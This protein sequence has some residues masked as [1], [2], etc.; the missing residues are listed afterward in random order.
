MNQNPEVSTSTETPQDKTWLPLII[1]LLAQIQMAFNV[2]ALPVSVGPI[3]ET[4][5]TSATS[6]GTALVIYSLFVAAFVILGA[7]FG[8]I[9]G[10][11][12]VFQVS[13]IVHGL[14]MGLMAFSSDVNTMNNAQAIAGLAAAA[15][16]PTLV[17][18]IATNYH[19]RQ[20]AQALGIMAGTPAMS[21]AVAFFVAGFL[22]TALS[23]RVSFGMLT[24]LSFVVFFLSF[25][26][27]SINRQSGIKIDLV[28]A[29]LVAMAVGLISFGFNN[30]L[31]WGVLL[32]NNSAP[33]SVLGLSPAMF[34]IVL[35]LVFGQ[36][37]FTWSHR[38]LKDNEA[39]LLA[40][41]VLDSSQERANIF[42]LLIISALG[43]AVNF[44]IPLYLQ[45]VQ[46]RT[47]LQTSVTV[48]PYTLA[49]VASAVLIIRLYDRLS[50]RQIGVAAFVIV[51][52]G[53]GLLAIS[54]QNDWGS[55]PIIISLI[56]VGLGEGALVTLLFNVMVTEA[57]K[58]LA[59]DVGALRGTVNN[60]STALGTAAAS[61]LV[62]SFLT[63]M[64][65]SNLA[66][67]A[68]L[69]RSLQAQVNLDS[70]NFVSNDE[71]KEI[72]SSTTATPEQVDEAV[73]LNE[74]ARLQSLKDAFLVLAAISLLAIIPSIWLPKYSP[75]EVPA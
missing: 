17:V 1:I 45:I 65:T 51:A 24:F 28:G 35:G 38:R 52:L 57:P 72:L 37:F 8:K 42:C 46:G 6:V 67:N 73:R 21:G 60:L 29:L 11:R 36:A 69:P 16:V 70:I 41:E 55:L 22:A 49:I 10:A 19:G 63:L 71:L 26:L 74:E 12:L 53:L 62:V 13:V 61:I 44:L 68:V 43:P 7:K 30:L 54:V 58:E 47:S 20:Q 32:A 27:K 34:M 50:S 15:L 64:V 31:T 3:S 18:L 23:W 40:P 4:L 56:I 9:F 75:G 59:G 2:N 48:V 14:A 66:N 39:T 33:F 5:G 25:R